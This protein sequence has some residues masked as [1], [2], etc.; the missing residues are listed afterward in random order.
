MKPM[1]SNRIAFLNNYPPTFKITSSRKIIHI[2]IEQ[3]KEEEKEKQFPKM[4]TVKS[5]ATLILCHINLSW[6]FIRG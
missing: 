1:V 3:Q 5:R 4:D 2:D 6:I